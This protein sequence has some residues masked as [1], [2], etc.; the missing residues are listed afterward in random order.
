MP[1]LIVIGVLALIVIWA[2]SLYNG[3]VRLRNRR[4]NANLH[5]QAIAFLFFF[6]SHH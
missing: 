3:L 6:S 5:Q 1:V 2:I 4:E